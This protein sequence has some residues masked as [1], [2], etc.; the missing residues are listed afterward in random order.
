MYFCVFIYVH[1]KRYASIC[2]FVG[3]AVDSCECRC[4]DAHAFVHVYAFISDLAFVLRS[5][6][7]EDQLLLRT[8]LCLNIQSEAGEDFSTEEMSLFLQG[9]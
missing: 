5:L 7:E 8:L 3:T 4:R 9:D 2:V 6:L 1:T